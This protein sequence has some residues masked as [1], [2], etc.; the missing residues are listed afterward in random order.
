MLMK[1]AKVRVKTNAGGEA[2][3]VLGANYAKGG[4][5]TL[6][7]IYGAYRVYENIV[8]AGLVKKVEAIA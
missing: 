7:R 5:V 3:G 6:A 1:G 8:A 2:V 4:A